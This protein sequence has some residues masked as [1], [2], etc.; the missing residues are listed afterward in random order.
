MSLAKTPR[1][2]GSSVLFSRGIGDAGCGGD[3]A[4]GSQH[5]YAGSTHAFFA[6]RSSGHPIGEDGALAVAH[7]ASA[8]QAYAGH[9]A[10]GGAGVGRYFRQTIEQAVAVAE[11]QG[12]KGDF[13]ER[14]LALL[15]IRNGPRRVPG[16]GSLRR[17]GERLV[18][19]NI[20]EER[21][22]E[23]PTLN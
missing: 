13:G 14:F 12:G 15:R 21:E 20:R 5:K 8:L 16:V 6:V 19:Y 17:V 18:G 3:A 1:A 22:L 7:F 23:P 4:V 9:E 10:L 11:S 2:Q